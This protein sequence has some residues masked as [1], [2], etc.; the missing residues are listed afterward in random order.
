MMA[1]S[2]DENS[3]RDA[4]KCAWL[5]DD[6]RGTLSAVFNC[7]SPIFSDLVRAAKLNPTT[8]LRF[9]NLSG[10]DFRGSDLRGYNFH[11][12]NLSFT[13]LKGARR[14][15]STILTD[16]NIEGAVDFSF[17]GVGEEISR[18]M[19]TSAAERASGSS[20]YRAMRI[21]PRAERDAM[22]EIYSFCRAVDD[23]ADDPG[24]REPRRAQLQTWR[25]DMD[26]LYA[27]TPPQHL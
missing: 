25:V 21:L 1:R 8:D 18:P 27:G 10:V 2:S 16:T 23:I 6:D 7:K 13:K 3:S 22:F 15:S 20:F 14:D 12:A 24:P 9:S 17:E 4:L 5:N 19:A 26:A 11:G